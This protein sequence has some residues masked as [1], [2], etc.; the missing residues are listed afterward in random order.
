M[1][2][3]L[4]WRSHPMCR[5]C[6]KSVG[7]FL[8]SL[9]LIVV[10]GTFPA[11]ETFDA[12][13]LYMKGM[14][15]SLPVDSFVQQGIDRYETGAFTAAIALWQEA[16]S[17]LCQNTS[18]SDSID[19]AVIHTNLARAYR[20]IGQIDLAIANWKTAFKIYKTNDRVSSRDRKN[21]QQL[22][23]L[24]TDIAQAYNDLGQHQRAIELL[25]EAQQYNVANSDPIAQA[26]IEGS[27][28]KAYWGR[29]EYDRAIVSLTTS[30]EIARE[31]GNIG[32]VTTAL[33]NLGNVYV[34]RADRYRYQAHVAELE[35]D[36]AEVERLLR[37]AEEDTN[38]AKN[39][40]E[41]SVLEAQKIGGMKEVT[42]LLNFN[43]ML[44][45]LSRSNSDEYGLKIAINRDRALE[46]LNT[47]PDSQEKAYALINIASSTLQH[48][49]A[50]N[51]YSLIKEIQ[52]WLEQ[53]IAGAQKIGDRRSESFALGTLGQL[54]E[55]VGEYQRA[56][57]LTRQAQFAA[58]QV[59][60]ADS[61]YRWQWQTARLLK[62]QKEAQ[63]A[64]ASY[65]QAIATLQS[66]RSDILAANPDIQFDF[67]DAVE[68][69]YRELISLLLDRKQISVSSIKN[70][71]NDSSNMAI[72]FQLPEENIREAL[73]VLELLKLAE[74][75]NFFGDDCVE[76]AQQTAG[77]QNYKDTAVIYSVILDSRTEIILQLPSNN[78]EPNLRSY[79]I[80]LSS[81]ELQREIDLFRRFL[82]KRNT[83]EYL[84]ISQKIYN[85]LIRPLEIDLS[86][87]KPK[88]LV[89]IND[90]VLRKVPMAALHDGT[91]FLI[92]KYAIATTPSLSVT[93]SHA[94]SNELKA[95]SLG[96][97]VERPPFAALTNVESE[98]ARVKAIL[99][100]SKLLD[101]EFTFSRLQEQFKKGN[102]SLVHMATHGKF[103][104][105]ADN[106][107]LLLF[108]TKITIEQ[109]DNLLRS[110]SEGQ[111]VELLTLS[112][113]QTA[114]GDNRAALGIAGVAVRAGVNSALATLWYIN[115]AATVPLIEEFYTQLKQP[116][117]TKAE[118]LQKAQ[119][120]MIE[121]LAYNHPA[122][123]SPFILIGNWQ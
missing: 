80:A 110:Y 12:K 74:L 21:Q 30:I 46:I 16:L 43:R 3:L 15:Q 114:A 47:L 48:R 42:T 66:I 34:S 77:K 49:F 52:E 10:I 100:G 111:P 89:F 101:K 83:E 55:T 120:K 70:P 39:A 84:L 88:T 71:E 45:Q 102:Y 72:D 40:F 1:R 103:G 117:V 67:R 106:T 27:L 61:L 115:D 94:R 65:K 31:G 78:Q 44:E 107:F 13:F 9:F 29:G 53:A 64:I 38:A 92:Q 123:W 62:Q 5:Y 24:L 79:S 18:C 81:Q 8:A 25:T 60:A 54:Y 98:V 63:Q 11:I 4:P 22:T 26:A 58:Q 116:K 2:G 119:I 32:Y 35:G 112:A 33:N 91:E 28:G 97:T 109:I 105:D 37:A 20:Q 90:G 69:V 93:T 56:M 68:P 104:A 17:Q 99:G 121:N 50:E 85:F 73:T 41:Q 57:Q 95:L 23:R 14:A 113:C 7:L 118:A 108:D 86:A 76:V 75:R 6:A 59:N 36:R 96:L 19:A 122:V 87:A 82:E 51:D